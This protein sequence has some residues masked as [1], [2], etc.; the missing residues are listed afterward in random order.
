MAADLLDYVFTFLWG[1]PGAF[2]LVLSGVAIITSLVARLYA[3]PREVLKGRRTVAYFII[4][5]VLYTL[6][7]S[8]NTWTICDENPEARELAALLVMRSTYKPLGV[9]ILLPFQVLFL[10]KGWV[11]TSFLIA[12]LMTSWPSLVF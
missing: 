3:N 11:I 8:L 10:L 12:L 5:A 7:D 1:T 2:L 9:L 6:R 4:A